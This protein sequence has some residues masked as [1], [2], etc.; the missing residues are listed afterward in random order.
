MHV[1]SCAAS[2]R[3]PPD[4]T[5]GEAMSHFV[6]ALP[7]EAAIERAAALMAYEGVGQIVVTDRGGALV[8]IVS[9]LDITRH[10]AIRSG[11]LAEGE[12]QRASD[13]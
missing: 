4:G 12:N 9:A 5:A 11:Y 7:R 3:A 10:Y 13:G 8:G 2:S 6:F 1:M